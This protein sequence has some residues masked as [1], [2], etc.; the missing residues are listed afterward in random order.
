MWSTLNFGGLPDNIKTTATL[1]KVTYQVMIRPW[2][3]W[4]FVGLAFVILSWS[5]GYFIWVCVRGPYSSNTS[6]LLKSTYH[7]RAGAH[8]LSKA[9]FADLS[10]Q[11]NIIV[12][13]VDMKYV[14]PLD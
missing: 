13:G 11:L 7:L 4:A 6:I 2:T 8:D 9:L 3:V 14:K 1:Q 10:K 5:I 12:T